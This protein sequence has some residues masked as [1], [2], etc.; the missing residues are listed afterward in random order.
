MFDKIWIGLGRRVINGR[1]GAKD[2]T[3]TGLTAKNN[4]GCKV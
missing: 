4:E 2:T 3:G 1:M